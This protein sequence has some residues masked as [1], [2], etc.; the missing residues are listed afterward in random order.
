[1]IS[2]LIE[3]IWIV[4]FYHICY[5]VIIIKIFAAQYFTSYFHVVLQRVVNLKAEFCIFILQKWCSEFVDILLNDKWLPVITYWWGVIKLRINVKVLFCQQKGDLFYT[6]WESYC[7]SKQACA[8]DIAILKMG[9]Q[10]CASYRI[11]LFL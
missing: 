11:I 7:F 1:M 3:H 4:K 2:V 5:K 9:V 8:I 6:E 10:N